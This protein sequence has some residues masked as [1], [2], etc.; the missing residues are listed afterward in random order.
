MVRFGIAMIGILLIIWLLAA[1]TPYLAKLA[2]KL[3]GKAEI[4]QGAS[5]V[6]AAPNPE[7]VE[8]SEDPTAEAE[9]NL[10]EE[11]RN[12]RVY[13]IY[14]GFPEEAGSDNDKKD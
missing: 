9:E 3:L 2:D 12:Y 4:K 8:D 14:E 5:S 13:D 6:P 1:G 11:I 7:R 10:P